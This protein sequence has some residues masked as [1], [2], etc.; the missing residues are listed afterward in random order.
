MP[1]THADVITTGP[2]KQILASA[3]VWEQRTLML[4]DDISPDLL[5]DTLREAINDLLNE[6]THVGVGLDWTTVRVHAHQTDWDNESY[7]VTRV[8]VL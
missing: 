6:S 7:L 1:K 4:T 8:D 5:P 2:D 3:K